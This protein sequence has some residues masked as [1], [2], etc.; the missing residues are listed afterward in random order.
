MYEGFWNESPQFK[1]LVAKES[2]DDLN[3]F[4]ET[5]L[6]CVIEIDSDFAGVIAATPSVLH[7]LKGWCMRERIISKKYRGQKLGPAV[8]WKFLLDIPPERNDILYGM[9]A[10]TNQA[11]IRS[12]LNLG[13]IDVGGIYKINLD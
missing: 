8:L 7:G 10:V 11:S 9:I 2:K 3:R 5:G 1:S 13:R 6:L 12:A 4:H